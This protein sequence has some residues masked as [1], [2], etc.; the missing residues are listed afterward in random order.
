M[1]ENRSVDGWMMREIHRFIAQMN[2]QVM[3]KFHLKKT[4]GQ[5]D[6]TVGSTA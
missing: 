2:F 6:G 3:G 1:R 4:L 5:R